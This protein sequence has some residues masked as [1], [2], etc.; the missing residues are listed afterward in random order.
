[1]ARIVER[2]EM[3]N[4]EQV[5]QDRDDA[6]RLLARMLSP[7][8]SG[9]SDLVVL[10]VP[11]GGVPVALRIKEALNAVL[12]VVIV[13]KLKIPGNPE[14]GFG[15][16]TLDGDLFVNEPL[17]HQLQLSEDQIR[18]QTMAVKETLEKRNRLLRGDL[19][20]PDLDGKTVILADDGIASGYTMLA[21]ISMAAK[22]NAAKIVVAVPTAPRRTLDI[23]E[24]RVDEIYC[25]NIREQPSFAVAAAYT[26]WYDLS[27]AQVSEMLG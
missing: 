12:D 14:A 24:E 4:R 5:F 2:Q 25:P 1:M 26:D 10:A 6:G 20:F 17:L 27:E 21:T 23:L 15:A 18:H 13:R 3:R 19:T 11:M 8:Y 16:M 9:A 7:R 22:R